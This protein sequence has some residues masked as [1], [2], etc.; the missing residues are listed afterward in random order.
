[1]E[2]PE[3]AVEWVKSWMIKRAIDPDS[4]LTNYTG[5]GDRVAEHLQ[6]V[7]GIHYGQEL[8]RFLGEDKRQMQDV[9]GTQY[10]DQL[11]AEL[12]SEFD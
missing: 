6:I 10:I 9:I 1:M 5:I 12:E 4:D 11:A 8:Y 7:Y 3:K 2:S